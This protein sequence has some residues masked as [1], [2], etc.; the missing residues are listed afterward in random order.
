MQLWSGAQDGSM[1]AYDMRYKPSEP[2][3]QLQQVCPPFSKPVGP[4]YQP[5]KLE[6]KPLYDNYTEGLAY[7]CKV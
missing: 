2:V 4:K 3:I 1:H 5:R 7:R 6:P